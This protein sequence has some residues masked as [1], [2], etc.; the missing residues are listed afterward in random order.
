MKTFKFGGI[1]PKENKLTSAFSIEIMPMSKLLAIPMAQHIGKPAALNVKVGDEVKKGQCIADAAGFIS[2]NVH[3]PTSG[4]IKKID[5][6]PHSCGKFTK[7][8]F[9]EPDGR[10][11]WIEGLNT[12]EVDFK[13]FSLEEKL[14]RVKDAGIVGMGGAGF[15]AHVKLMPPKDKKIDTLILN[16]AECEP[17]LTA[18]HRLMLE[19]PDEI[20]KGL[21]II[22]SFFP[23]DLKVYIGIE[24]NK[25]D[26]I[27][28]MK[29]KAAPLGFEVVVLKPRYPQGGEKQLINAITGRTVGNGQL[30]FDVGCMVNNIATAFAIYEAVCKNKPLVERVFTVSGMAIRNKKNIKAPIGTM[31]SDIVDYCGGIENGKMNL[32]ISGGPMMGKAQY[33]FDVPVIKTTSGIL[34]ID[35][36][37]LEE[38]KER[39]CLRCGRCETVCP[40]NLKPILLANLAQ[41]DFEQT[42]EYGLS[43]C[44]ECGSCAFVCPSKRDLVHWIKYAKVMNLNLKEMEKCKTQA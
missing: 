43:Q 23:K 30:P 16:G 21:E 11:E 36:M 28:L 4:K 33:S 22:A 5:Q 40:I 29:E 39:P 35:E 32:L 15:P 25:K 10:E 27:K 6:H 34:F 24:N 7:T 19:K 3:A 1:H 37:K 31:F 38:K 14:K 9:I 13:K 18:D 26:A 2:A 12:E 42:Q 8:V 17:Y 44:M 20:L 41:T